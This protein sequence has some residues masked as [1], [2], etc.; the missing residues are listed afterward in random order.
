M[1]KITSKYETKQGVDL[2]YLNQLRNNPFLKKYNITEDNYIEFGIMLEQNEN[3]KNCKG[4]NDCKNPSIGYYKSELC[5][6]NEYYFVSSP[7]KFKQA[8]MTE[9]KTKS[10]LNTLYISKKVL[11]A[12]LEDFHLTTDS[13]IKGAKYLKNFV[14]TFSI[15]EFQK[16]LLLY[17]P[18]GSGKTFLLSCLANELAKHKIDSLMIYVPDLIRD[19]KG[20]IGT[21]RLEETMNMLKTVPILI[22]DDLGS[23]MMTQWVRDEILSPLFNYRMMDEKPLFIS[24]NLNPNS[25]TQHFASTNT[26]EDR[27][28]GVRI[29]TRL[30]SL[31]NVLKFE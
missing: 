17:G 19:L 3:C 29:M 5:I 25:L 12:R 16:G 7:C 20:A 2:E 24:S 1:K 30:Q 18:C 6:E 22:L 28:K 26:D 23:E 27:M 9:T 4:I 11:N 14:N 15:N 21:P 8:L 13:R 31:A 10:Y